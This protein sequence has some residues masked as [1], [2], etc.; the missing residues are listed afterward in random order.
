MTRLITWTMAGFV[1]V[2]LA[3][4]L[5]FASGAI[6][7]A[8]EGD[9][10]TA[11]EEPIESEQSTEEDTQSEEE[12]RERSCGG[13]KYLIK[14]AAVEVLGVT[15]E[16]LKDALQ[17]GQSLAQIAEAQGMS[18]ADFRAALLASVTDDL[19]A[20]LSAG[21]ITQAEFDEIT[22]EL[23]EK[24]DGVINAEG[25]LGFHSRS[26]DESE[27][28]ESGVRFGIRGAPVAPGTDV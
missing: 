3:I 26:G 22:A 18:V 13:G 20:Q 19:D 10:P 25:G 23:E 2:G 15:E 9:D 6:T 4:G 14:E 17:E 7:F 24:L 28:S 1:T 12:A 27:N 11:T 8:Q 21:E 5:L 16:E